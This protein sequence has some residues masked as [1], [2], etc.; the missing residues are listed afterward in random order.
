MDPIGYINRVAN[1][2]LGR[3]DNFQNSDAYSLTVVL[4]YLFFVLSFSVGA[5]VLSY[6][7]NRSIGT[8]STPTVIYMMLAFLF[9]YFY[10]PFYVLVLSSRK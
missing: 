9:S 1:A 8:G 3:S 4:I 5:A 6:R 2:V 10:Y 7:Y